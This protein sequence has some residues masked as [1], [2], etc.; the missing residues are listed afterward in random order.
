MSDPRLNGLY[1]ITDETI[2]DPQQLEGQVAQAIAGGARIVQYRDKS[3][4]I[5]QRLNCAER[6]ATLCH[7]HRIPLIIN[8]DIELA[9]A[10]CAEGVHLGR[11]DGDLE[12]AR[13][14]LPSDA[15]IGISC[16][17]SLDLAKQAQCAGASYVAF[18]R[19]FP[20]QSKPGATP[21]DPA[22]LTQAQR[23]L[24]L[25]IVAIGGITLENGRSLIEAGANMLAVINGVFGQTDISTAA[26]EFSALFAH[27]DNNI[28]N[29]HRK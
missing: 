5:E 15:I 13:A 2:T 8:D 12:R 17:D 22:I 21:A 19:F 11:E 10:C 25:P 29:E 6:L 16:Y 26:R 23:Q 24:Q 28:H 18:G 3:R 7:E 4:D 14:R 9:R 27:N 1:A 20:S